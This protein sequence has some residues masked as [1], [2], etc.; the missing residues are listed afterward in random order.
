MALSLA[1]GHWT[2][3]GWVLRRIAIVGAGPE[4]LDL[5][6][7]L[8]AG[9]ENLQICGVFDDRGED[10]VAGNLKDYPILGK[11]S[12]LPS[13]GR[14]TR[15]DVVLVALP[16][17]AENRVAQIVKS[18]AEMPVDVKLSALASH[19]RLSPRAYS[20][21]G[22]TSFLDITDKP[23]SHW[24]AV[25]KVVFDKVLATL[26]LV[27]L[28]PVMLLTAIA[29]KLDSK[30]PVLFKQKR[31]GFNNERSSSMFSLAISRSW[32]RDPTR[33]RPR[34]PIGSIRTPSTATSPGTK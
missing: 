16:T 27:A 11:I 15:I 28:S 12:D 23:I 31:Y 25:Q 29:I 6:R 19:L 13:V 18:L 3:Q 17:R 33:C 5:I 7:S 20:Y 2:R 10:R 32:V 30:G 8:E 21:I 22:S 4:G 9:K 14:K 24:S 1:V 34:Q 26:A